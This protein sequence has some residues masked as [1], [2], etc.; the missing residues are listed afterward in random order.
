MV[1][2]S[3]RVASAGRTS[4]P[5]RLMKGCRVRDEAQPGRSRSTANWTSAEASTTP[6]RSLTR[7]TPR[8]RLDHSIVL[9]MPAGTPPETVLPA[10][11]IFA[12]QHHYAMVLHAN[13]AHLVVKWR[14]RVRGRQAPVQRKGAFTTRLDNRVAQMSTA[15]RSNPKTTRHVVPSPG[16]RAAMHVKSFQGD[17]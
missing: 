6:S 1:K 5:S 9:S 4:C 17:S 8:A 3:S 7:K 16:A 10:A 12:L 13:Q 15:W 11:R 14:A 2:V